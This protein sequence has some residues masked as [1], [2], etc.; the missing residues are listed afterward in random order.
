EE[1]DEDNNKATIYLDVEEDDSPE[2]TGMGAVLLAAGGI[3][4]GGVA[5]ALYI[6]WKRKG[7]L[8]PPK[9]PSPPSD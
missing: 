5:L 3:L 1:K 8:I 2:A 4:V 6:L 7:Y 9:S